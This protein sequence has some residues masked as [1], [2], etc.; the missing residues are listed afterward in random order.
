[1]H[2]VSNA[3]WNFHC[4]ATVI[5]ISGEPRSGR[6]QRSFSSGF[7]ALVLILSKPLRMNFPRSTKAAIPPPRRKTQKLF[8]S[9]NNSIIPMSDIAILVSADGNFKTNS[10]TTAR[11]HF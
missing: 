2:P 6:F 1:M 3:M 7:N 9:G 10:G 8:F 5:R 4:S 11:G